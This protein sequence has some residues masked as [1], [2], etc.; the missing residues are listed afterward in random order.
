MAKGRK[1]KPDELKVIAGT[2]RSDRANAKAP[3]VT[4][5]IPRAPEYLS[6]LATEY[7]GRMVVH[8]EN[9]GL[10]ALEYESMIGIAAS[11]QA[12]IEENQ[13]FLTEQEGTSYKT[14]NRGGDEIWKQYPQVAHL[15]DA[16]RH[17]QSILSEFGMSPASRSKATV[18]EKKQPG[19]KFGKLA[20]GGA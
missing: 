17:L 4:V 5:G 19:S 13:K 15:S 18:V 9:M 16:R 14:K 2:F 1:P 8:L 12:E 7:F 20:N 10:C 11:L 6:K 3:E